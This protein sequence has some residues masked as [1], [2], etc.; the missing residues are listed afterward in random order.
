M[1]WRALLMAT[2]LLCAAPTAVLRT[3]AGGEAARDG[4]LSA[5]AVPPKTLHAPLAGTGRAPADAGP[6]P[7]DDG[8][9]GEAATAMDGEAPTV[10][11]GET[12]TITDD[13]AATATDGEPARGRATAPDGRD[14]PSCV[15]THLDASIVLDT[16]NNSMSVAARISLVIGRDTSSVIVRLGP[17]MEISSITDDSG[18]DLSFNN[19]FWYFYNVS[20]GNQF[21]AGT[22]VNITIRYGGVVLNTDDDG[23]SFWDYVGADASWVRAFGDYFPYDE[24]WSR[25][26]SRVSLTVPSD[27]TAVSSGDLTGQSADAANGTATFVW[28]ND[29][30]ES[31]LAFVSGALD[32]ASASSGRHRYDLYLRA[33]HIGAASA[34][35]D[36]LARID[37]FYTSLFGDAG[38]VNLT[39]AE[40][41]SNFSAW[42]ESNPAFIWLASR[43][44]GGPLPYRILSHEL[45]HQWWGVDIEGEGAGENWLQEGFAGYSEAM[46]EKTYYGD[47]G[48]L[49]FCRQQYINE[50]VQ[51]QASEPV[52]VSNDYDLASY[53][54]PWVLHMLRYLVGDD[55]FD[56]TMAAF[57][58]DHS[59]GRAD[60]GAFQ[61]EV[62]RS[63]G[64]N[65]SDFFLG[66]FYSSGRLDYAVAGALVLQGPAGLSRVQLTVQSRGLMGGMP[67]DVGIYYNG[68]RVALHR[69]AWNG[70]SANVSL[71]FDVDYPVDAVRLD[72]L[73]WLFDA[74][75][76][77]NEAPTT[78]AFYDF[79]VDGVLAAPAE[80]MEDQSFVVT[81]GLS[82]NSSEGRQEVGVCLFVDGAPEQNTTVELGAGPRA[83][84]NF[85]LSLG[86]GSH[87]LTVLADPQNIFY[88]RSGLVPEAALWL[89][90][91]P[92]PP[93]LPN[94]RIPPGG[95]FVSPRDAVGGQPAELDVVVENSGEADVSGVT[96]DCWVDSTDTGYAGRSSALT[97]PA[98]ES[99]TASVN[100]TAVPG[101]HQLSARVN[102]P[103]GVNES[104]PGDNEAATQVY[105]NALPV[106]ILTVSPQETLPGEWVEL[107]GL[108]STDDSRVAYYFFDFGD[109]GTAGWLA[110]GTTS[111]SYGSTGVYQA[112][113]M[114]QDDSGAQSDWSPPVQVRVL[115]AG[116]SAA[117]SVRPHLGDARTEFMF[118]SRASDAFGNITDL[119]WSFG[120]GTQS[121]GSQVSHNYSRH[122][123]FQVTLTVTDDGGLGAWAAITVP[124]LDIAPQPVIS[125]YGGV[126]TIGQKVAFSARNSTD[127]DDGSSNLTFIWDFGGG[128][129][130]SGVD[131]SFAFALP[132]VH[133]VVLTASDGNLSA[134]SALMLT[135]RVAPPAPEAVRSDWTAWGVL[136]ALLL[137]MGLLA[138]GIM[139]P[140][141]RRNREEEE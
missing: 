23:A 126:A 62:A 101:W 37:G 81:A 65:L 103:P 137:A 1:M 83:Q 20:L 29:R 85:S 30:P 14:A 122:G 134:E 106:P 87:D 12:A 3:S 89:M 59:G 116:P 52:L 107:S 8:R 130:A 13:G 57:H 113:L 131:A 100:W 46:Y 22:A 28:E 35:S 140:V 15:F 44:F 86:A 75:P 25:T 9:P 17:A 51:S 114:V 121:R 138:A 129:K 82:G 54:G 68:G 79:R 67:V 96:V 36:E 111:H 10:T 119:L 60:L 112:R 99:R 16:P 125:Y 95:I 53:K 127:Q 117:I 19:V 43:N 50:F 136:G 64:Q 139:T 31:G 98:G 18:E 38:F 56:R 58:D 21:P 78:D 108:S 63:T 61:E 6:G 132:G 34:F 115:S 104:D 73:D 48:Y 72:P 128:Q 32:H 77:N 5:R 124:V 91:A 66:W 49:E 26:T 92:R 71:A 90:V 141:K 135:V 120:D 123:D 80:P 94:L 118:A 76:T 45:A 109:G 88:E 70:S 24:N 102:P 47:W 110:D 93:P 2:I 33:D 11:D 105:I 97:V 84:A 4:N 69:S 7:Q 39:V 55:A 74:H 40:V 42:G 133:Y 27:E 41:P